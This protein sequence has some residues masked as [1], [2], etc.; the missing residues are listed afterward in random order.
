MQCGASN[1]NFASQEAARNFPHPF[2]WG[3]ASFPLLDDHSPD[4]NNLKIFLP[5]AVRQPTVLQSSSDSD[6]VLQVPS[7]KW[8]TLLLNIYILLLFT[9]SVCLKIISFFHYLFYYCYFKNYENIFINSTYCSLSP[10]FSSTPP[11]IPIVFKWLF[12]GISHLCAHSH[13]LFLFCPFFRCPYHFLWIPNQPPC[14]TFS[15]AM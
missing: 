15:L 6:W 9:S 2:G 1:P 14:C 4:Q 13:S 10:W 11:Y 7:T 8:E 12:N 5:A 3:Q